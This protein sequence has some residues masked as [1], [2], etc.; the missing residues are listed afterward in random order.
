M[1]LTEAPTSNMIEWAS[2]IMEKVSGGAISNMISTGMHSAEVWE[3]VLFQLLYAMAVMHKKEIY[4][5]NFSIQNNVFIKDLFTDMS[6]I[7]HWI[8]NINDIDM[9]VP[10]Y[11]HVV[12]IDS[13]YVDDEKRASTERKIIGPIF[14]DKI[15][16][17]NMIVDACIKIFTSSD[18]STYFHSQ[19]GM[20]PPEGPTIALIERIQSNMKNERNFITT[21]TICFPQYIHNRVGTLLTK[22]ER[23]TLSTNVMPKLTKGKMVVYQ[24]RYDEYRWVLYVGNDIGKKKQILLLENNNL[25]MKQVFNH[26]LFEHPD[27]FNINQNSEKNYKLTK[28]T[29]I[30]KYSLEL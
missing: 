15:D 25:I 17:K 29:L 26:S 22:T 13:R 4:I 11:G 24:S 10:N 8:Y 12:M 28:E 16:V 7:G 6:N 2:P 9:Y 21:L 18:F 14:N 19:Y 5:R 23:D 30:E 1:L 20:L 27:A 3:S